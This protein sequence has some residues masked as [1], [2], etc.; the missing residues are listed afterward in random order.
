MNK[1]KTIH[2]LIQALKIAVGSCAAILIATALQLNF[3]TSSGIITLLSILTTK[4]ETVKISI[5]RMISFGITVVL[6]I[7]VFH[8]FHIAWLEF[9]I[10]I[11]LLV[12][13]CEMIG[14]KATISVNAVVGTHFLTTLDFSFQAIMNEFLLVLIGV[15]IAILLNL[16]QNNGSA[17]KK[18]IANMRYT[19]EKL[20]MIMEELAGYMK[21]EKLDHSVWGDII[22]LEHELAQ[23]VEAAYKYQNNTFSSHPSY[24]I[25]YFEMR[26]QQCNVLHNLHYQMKRL[27]YMPEQARII[28]AYITYMKNYI[29]EINIP[30]KQIEALNDIFAD[31]KKEPLPKT[32]EEFENRAILYH[33]LLDLEEFLVFKKRF[34]ES[35]EDVHKEIYWDDSVEK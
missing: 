9:G 33:I 10:F 13:I 35:L 12:I 20:Q 32:R 7:I 22:E 2:V 3:A 17:K 27:R 14:W 6:S 34:V 1:E 23:F 18:I 16:F 4:W 30:T 19:E 24:Y 28:A 5:F 11:F 26:T 15:A 8:L 29:V 25:H 21:L 31:M